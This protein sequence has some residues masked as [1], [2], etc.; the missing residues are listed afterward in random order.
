V[1]LL[2][3]QGQDALWAAWAVPAYGAAAV[4]A[5]R[6]A[7]SS[8]V[9][10]TTAAFAVGVPLLILLAQNQLAAGMVVIE[11]SASL[12]LRHG[13]PYLGRSRLSSWIAY[14][15]YLPAMAV[16]GLPSAAGV[17]GA[18]GTPQVWLVL[19]T[20]AVLTGVFM[21]GLPHPVARCATC[22]GDLVCRTAFAVACPVLAL[23][24]AVTTTDV[25]VIAL[26]LLSL[27][28]SSPQSAGSGGPVQ[29]VQS[30]GSGRI[31]RSGRVVAAAVVLGLACA[32]K[33]TAWPAI[34]VL[35]A[36]FR[37][38][39]GTKAALTFGGTAIGIVVTVLLPVII[40]NP[41]AMVENAV[42]FPL[43]LTRQLTPAGSATP[44][45][46]LA[47]TG[48]AGHAL[49]VALLLAAA[50]G[51]AASL[52]WRPPASTRAAGWRLAIG[53]ALMFALGPDER[54]GYFSYPLAI[55]G[56]LL[57]TR[58]GTQPCARRDAQL[59]ARRGTQPVDR[60]AGAGAG[61]A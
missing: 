24:L 23:N 20:V 21:V 37:T 28:L 39:D 15:P 1:F 54:F 52:V 43:G 33:P 12:V 45:D 32:M 16:F 11:R 59:S 5:A 47:R 44:G 18:P 48:P 46:L 41:V 36:M 14:N 40:A 6:G 29:S 30:A 2:V 51:V 22:R 38:R 17:Q 61:T 55:A 49:A 58:R 8:A 35:G 60:P 7:R 31:A 3:G 42:L 9:A 57:L 26:M 13:T 25:P 4:L 56:W 27:A 19:G 34:L 10:L 50:I 53:L